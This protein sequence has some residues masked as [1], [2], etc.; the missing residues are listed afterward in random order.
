MS[1]DALAALRDSLKDPS[2]SVAANAA[3]A[4]LRLG[5]PPAEA[6]FLLKGQRG[7]AAAPELQGAARV[8]VE[9]ATLFRAKGMWES[10]VRDSTGPTRDALREL[11]DSTHWAL[12]Q[13]PA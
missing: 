2:P 6:L 4:L 9:T 5:A 10:R 8:K 11:L 13:F 3:V 12:A 7:P 1:Q